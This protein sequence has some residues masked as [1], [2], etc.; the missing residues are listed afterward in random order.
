MPTSTK[1]DIGNMK[2]LIFIPQESDTEMNG[3]IKFFLYAK[4]IKIIEMIL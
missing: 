4:N 1:K 2:I 3:S